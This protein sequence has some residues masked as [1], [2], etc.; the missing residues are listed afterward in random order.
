[1]NT[2]RLNTELSR[3]SEI[4]ATTLKKKRKKKKEIIVP[5]MDKRT[6]GIHLICLK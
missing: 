3:D 4:T 6:A 5:L 1:M 2:K